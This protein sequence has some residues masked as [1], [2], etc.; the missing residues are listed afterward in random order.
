VLVGGTHAEHSGEDMYATSEHTCPC[1]LSVASTT[2]L[3]MQVS[4]MLNNATI[5]HRWQD[6]RACW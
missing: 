5:D 2:T 3:L 4:F 6:M 1:R